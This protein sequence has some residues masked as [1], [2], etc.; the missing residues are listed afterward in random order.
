MSGFNKFLHSSI[1]NKFLVAITG[2][3]LIL[4]LIVHLLGNLLLLINEHPG[5]EFNAYS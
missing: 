1:G 3:F 5:E 2:L 4:F